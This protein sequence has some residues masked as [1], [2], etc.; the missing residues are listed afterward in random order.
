MTGLKITTHTAFGLAFDVE[1]DHS[2]KSGFKPAR[3]DLG[4]GKELFGELRLMGFAAALDT[5][6]A[7]ALVLAG[8]DEG[9]YRGEEPIINRAESIKK[10]LIEEHSIDPRTIEA[11]PSRS[12]TGGNIDIFARRV[13]E[14]GLEPH[15]CC[16]ITNHYHL[17]RA[18]NMLAN[19]GLSMRLVSAEAL[20]LVAA[21]LER[22]EDLLHEFGGGPLAER[23]CEEIQGIAEMIRGTYVP[24]TDTR[25]SL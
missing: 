2:S 24:R 17:P 3:T 6:F 19:K 8:G 14:S 10:M 22:K 9:R 23:D 21:G 4:S 18:A 13:Q 1:K 20:W 15:E 16:L 25:S 11:H 7:K 5:G 12:N